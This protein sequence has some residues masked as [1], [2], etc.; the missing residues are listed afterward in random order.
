[1]SKKSIFKLAN[2][3]FIAVALTAGMIGALIYPK[4][5]VAAFEL[6]ILVTLV[7]FA[8]A[9][10]ARGTARA[11]RTGTY[12]RTSK[13]ETFIVLPMFAVTFAVLAYINVDALEVVRALPATLAGS[14]LS[15]IAQLLFSQMYDDSFKKE[16]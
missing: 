12:K 5:F 2:V 15:T 8:F 4:N 3:V 7:G 9:E 16:Q 14:I 6:S 1:M 11:G 13:G 10:L